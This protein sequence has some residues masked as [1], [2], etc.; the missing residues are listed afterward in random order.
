LILSGPGIPSN[1]TTDALVQLTDV[2]PTLCELAEVDIPPTVESRSLVPLLQKKVNRIHEFVVGV[3]TDT[4]RMICNERWKLIVYPKA[5]QQQLF[6]LTSDTDEMTNLNSTPSHAS[7][8]DE[9][10]KKLTKWLQ[11]HRDPHL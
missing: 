5:N 9:L 6:D 3:Y 4:Q 1:E 2:F 7:V 8:R 11:E 10:K